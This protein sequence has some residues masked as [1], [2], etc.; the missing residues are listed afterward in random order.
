LN[1]LARLALIGAGLFFFAAPAPA[2]EPVPGRPL[3]F[4]DSWNNVAYYDTNNEKKGFAGLLGR[5]DERIGVYLFNSPLQ[6]YGALLCVTSQSPD[7]WDNALYYGP[8]IRI[9]PFESFHGSGWQDEWVRD[10][11]I[12]TESLTSSFLRDAASGEANKR[13]DVRYGLDLWHEWNLDNADP[14][15]CWGELWANLSRRSTNFEYADF[16]G[17]I[18][19]FQPKVGWHLGRGLE[20]YLR[21]DLTQSDK[22]SYWLNV[23]D[24]GI[25]IRVEP[26]RQMEKNDSFMKKFKMFAEILSVS[27]LK[28]RPTDPNKT[29]AS[30]LR[31]GVDFSYGR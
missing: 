9:K 17:Y 21:G 19:Y 5:F 15:V 13:Q 30:D 12:F 11:K 2:A 14:K 16:N 27:Y 26:W 1:N 6:I 18:L 20:A 22:S 31:F 25:G 28:D 10:V 4:L 7:Y 29:V 3:F 23:A 8:G 24:Y